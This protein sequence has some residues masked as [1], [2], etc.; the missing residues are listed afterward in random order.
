MSKDGTQFVPFPAP[1]QPPQ[2]QD[3]DDHPNRVLEFSNHD[4]MKSG[5]CKQ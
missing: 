4:Q 3:E 5:K 2:A 1:T